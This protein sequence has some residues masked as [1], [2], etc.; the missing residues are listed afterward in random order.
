MSKTGIPCY[1]SGGCGPYEMY[2]CNECP[3]SKSDYLQRDIKDYPPYLDYPKPRKPMTN[4]DLLISKT[5]EE[6]AEWIMREPSI[7]HSLIGYYAF[8]PPGIGG[9]CPISP[10]EQCWLDW[11]KSPVEEKE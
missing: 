5:P 10:C 2:S 9:D 3:A 11:L 7:M 4:Y 8:C 1:R 6:L